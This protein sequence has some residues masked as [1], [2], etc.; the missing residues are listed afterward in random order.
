LKGCYFRFEIRRFLC[1]EMLL[2][3]FVDCCVLVFNND[4]QAGRFR[5][6]VGTMS[7]PDDTKTAQIYVE[8][9]LLWSVVQFVH[10]LIRMRFS[11]Q[12][13]ELLARLTQYWMRNNGNHS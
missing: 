9:C 12:L 5:H 8:V 11:Y 2:N 4:D 1:M 6:L 10:L 3:I 7:P 13:T